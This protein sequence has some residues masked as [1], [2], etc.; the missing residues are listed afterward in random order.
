MKKKGRGKGLAK[1]KRG[2]EG[3]QKFKGE[4]Q[5]DCKKNRGRGGKGF[6]KK[7]KPFSNHFQKYKC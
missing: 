4:G 6:Q 2:G 3:L 5:I 1:K 7:G